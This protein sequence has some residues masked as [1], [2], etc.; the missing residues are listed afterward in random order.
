MSI[1]NK[2][3][4]G[5]KQNDMDDTGIIA[6][7]EPEMEETEEAS[8]TVSDTDDMPEDK[9]PAQDTP[10]KK[11]RS[12]KWRRGR[13]NVRKR[14]K[15]M[16]ERKPLGK[17]PFIIA[18]SIVGGLVL[19]YLAVAAF[20]MS[21][22][23]VNTTING[24]DFSGKTVADVE[25]YLET[26]VDGYQLKL[27]EQNNETD[28]I[29]GSDI[30]LVYIKNDDVKKALEDQRQL[31]WIISLFSKSDTDITV[32][33]KY[34]E[35]ALDEKI[36]S[37]KAVTAEQTDPVSAHPEYD[38][39]SFVVASETL[40]T[41]IDMDT[42]T[43]KIK[44]YISNF[45]PQLDLL[46]EECYMMPKY[47]SE[48]PE[49]QAACD[50]MNE[51]LKASI[52]YTMDED[53]VV[54]KELISTW[55]KCD[56]DMQV[57]FDEDAVR[58]WMREFGSKYDTKGK[59]RTITTPTGKSAEV[60][61]GT[62]GWSVDEKTEAKN[63]INSIKKGEVATREPAYEQTAASRSAQDWGTTY[64][65]VDLSAQHMWYIVDGSVAMETDVVTGLASDPNRATPQGVYSILEMKRNKTLVGETNPSTGEPSYRTP[66]SY[67]MR[68]TWTGIGF[69]DAIWQSSFGG[70]RYQ[71]RAGSHGC[72]NMPLDQAASL[73][74]MLSVGTPV[75]I[76]Y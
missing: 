32:D 48:S 73:Y 61:G 35:A 29:L 27:I 39:N 16:K 54:D 12:G 17:K 24:K 75:V 72:I 37:I 26:Q 4:S 2:W 15:K 55:L 7:V 46:E 19:I 58:D 50:T 31:L 14:E 57:I 68:V 20:F 13:H 76:H 71:T 51:Y 21:H 38:G 18:G 1:V 30:S 10:V 69:H 22:F 28:T 25:S 34:D 44:E 23:L 43:S 42:L 45:E 70:T 63:L 49:V 52:T 60:S 5:R 65:E 66:V 9:E 53:V 3:G 47:T 74:G 8:E 36:Q 33:V 6:S 59:T 11:R 64:V 67:W 62:Y 40:G 41:A 56:E